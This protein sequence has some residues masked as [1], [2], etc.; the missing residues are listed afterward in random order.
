[1]GGK[2]RKSLTAMEKAQRKAE[3]KRAKSESKSRESQTKGPS[4]ITIPDIRSKSVL[5]EV[6]KMK[7]LTPYTVASHF[8]LRLSVAK[9]MLEELH[10]RGVITYV[11]GGRNLKIYKPAE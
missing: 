4:G 9:D 11:S 6:R 5:N 3:K 8:N 1:M 2:K 10:Q 7:V